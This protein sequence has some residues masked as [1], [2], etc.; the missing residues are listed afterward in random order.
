MSL[1]F[2]KMGEFFFQI[3]VFQRF[4]NIK[5]LIK[6]YWMHFDFFIGVLRSL[7]QFVSS[8][9]CLFICLSVCLSVC[10]VKL[11]SFFSSKL[12][13]DIHWKKFVSCEA[14]Q[15]FKSPRENDVGDFSSR[16]LFKPDWRNQHVFPIPTIAGQRTVW[17][18]TLV[19]YKM[20]CW[21]KVCLWSYVFYFHFWN[22]QCNVTLPILSL[23]T[24]QK[25]C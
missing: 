6:P 2:L 8:S 25:R 3:I 9:V 18:H 1:T 10:Q 17:Q 11:K 7:S 22:G 13:Q 21:W 12:I 14:Q 16:Q 24:C 23:F 4:S 15:L 19:K 5:F 20:F